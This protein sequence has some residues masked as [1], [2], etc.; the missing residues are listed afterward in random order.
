V[1]E[2]ASYSP[3]VPVAIAIRGKSIFAQLRIAMIAMTVIA[4][5]ACRSNDGAYDAFNQAD[6]LPAI[7]L[8][9]QNGR[10][11]SLASLKGKPVVV[12]FI[13]T[14]CPRPCRMLTHKM[15][16]VARDLRPKF[17]SGFAMVSITV[18]PE[19][20]TPAKLAEYANARGIDTTGWFLLTGS[21]KDIDRVLSNFQL[22]RRRDPDGTV[23][24]I[25]GV[26]LL[27]PEGQ[28]LREYD[29]EVVKTSTIASDIEQVLARQPAAAATEEASR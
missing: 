19:H 24:H 3:D 5:A 17:G 15:A 9:D 20:D 13:Y 14:S 10:P 22:R 18:D 23:E 16:R 27:G 1:P 12:D 21:P 6:C 28:E 7:S 8:I 2:F 25:T 26:F 11:V 29:G 4:I